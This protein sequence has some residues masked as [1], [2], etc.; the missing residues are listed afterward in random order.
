[1]KII[2]ITDSKATFD[3]VKLLES[4]T[5]ASLRQSGHKITEVMSGTQSQDNWRNL[6]RSNDVIIGTDTE[7]L[8]ARKKYNIPIP[9]LIPS[10]GLGTRGLLIFREF[11]RLLR[12]GDSFFCPSSADLASANQLIKNESINTYLLPY[13]LP[14]MYKIG[15]RRRHNLKKNRYT[16]LAYIG[17]INQQK[18]IHILLKMVR[19]LLNRGF[20]IKLFIV[21][22]EDSSNCPELNLNNKEYFQH[23]DKLI[24]R[25]SLQNNVKMLGGL[26]P[27]RVI[28][29]LS[30]IN[31]HV[32]CST[33]RTEDFGFVPIEAMATGVPTIGTNWGGFLDTIEHGITGY[34]MPVHITKNG[35]RVNWKAGVNY[36]VKLITDK[37]LYSTL[38]GNC[39]SIAETK[40]THELFSHR[41]NSILQKLAHRNDNTK[42]S[43]LYS[44]IDQDALDYLTDIDNNL[45]KNKD[46]LSARNGLFYKKSRIFRFFSKYAPDRLPLWH[47]KSKI[48]IPLDIEIYNNHVIV[49]DFNWGKTIPITPIEYK[50]LHLINGILSINGIAQKM[51]LSNNKVIKILDS[52]FYKGLILP[53]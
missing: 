44:L 1:M 7:M 20:L 16:S 43:D 42:I 19:E 21:G 35:F 52:L 25:Y 14:P 4:N 49:E 26:P 46:G 17:R 11:R 38:S 2:F 10:Y 6:L 13:S 37:N 51:K 53:E 9:T 12:K 47:A 24:N 39:V 28:N 34:R 36:I 22:S 18:N 33:F 31:I 29:L 32:S 48:Y 41:L 40:Y 45:K 5:R 50:V 15:K 3:S 30:N 23:L 27:S 8:N